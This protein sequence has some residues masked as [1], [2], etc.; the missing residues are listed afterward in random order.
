MRRFLPIER[1]LVAVVLV[2]GVRA[3]AQESATANHPLWK[4]D[5]RQFGYQKFSS[6][7]VKYMRL[8]VDFAD[9]EHVAVAWISPDATKLSESKGPKLGDPA[10]L[11]VVI[12]DGRTGRK[13][14][15]KDWSAGYSSLPFLRGTA[16]GLLICTGNSL[17]LV[18][19]ALDVVR[20]EE[21]PDH[22]ICASTMLQLSPS[23]RRSLLTIHGE[24][25]HQELLNAETLAT[26]SAW[27]EPRGEHPDHAIAFSD[28]WLAGYCGEPSEICVRQSRQEEWRPLRSKGLDTRMEKGWHERASFLSDELLAIT[29]S[30]TTTI[31]TIGGEV[32]F[33]IK[34]PKGHFLVTPIPSGGGERFAV[35]EYRLRGLRSEPLD[36][37][38]SRADDRMFVYSIKDRGAV[39]SLKLEG[40]S[41][42]MPWNAHINSVAL[43]PKGTSL[44]V[45][46]D[47]LLTVYGLPEDEARRH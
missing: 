24:E 21:L 20:E 39:F 3:W 19:P 4:T 6:Q 5:L 35:I 41:P 26:I 25:I 8:A 23:R 32:M 38:P 47:A 29:Q 13:Q 7:S 36:M 12:L 17:R 18:S 15:Q 43:P 37:Y 30:S 9:D 31:A 16:N 45:L 1:A 10:H 22:G 11:H 14:N 34:S 44:A 46:S 40:M 27:T 28:S 33:Q 2:F 42:W